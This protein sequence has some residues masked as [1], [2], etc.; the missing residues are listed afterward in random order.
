M[1][2]DS[3]ALQKQRD[4]ADKQHLS[5]ITITYPPSASSPSLES[6][7]TR[8]HNRGLSG[9]ISKAASLAH[10]IAGDD[11]RTQDVAINLRGADLI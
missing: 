9:F 11:K 7:A 3:L 4:L 10:Y 6:M 2:A 1:Q 8:Q 5:E